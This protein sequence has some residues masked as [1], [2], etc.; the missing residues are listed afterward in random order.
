MKKSILLIATLL[1]TLA[2]SVQAQ[3]PAPASTDPIVQMR[4]EQRA[5]DKTYSDKKKALD[6]ERKVKVKAAGDKAAAEA[7]A[8]GADEAV[9]RREAESK[10]K[11]AT[12][13]DHDAKLK[14]FKKDRDAANAEIKKKY[15]PAAKP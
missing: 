7:K 2:G 4:A 5:V 14:A 8:K 6:G 13:T 15:P 1:A 10:V 9:A 3:A 12:K 11:A